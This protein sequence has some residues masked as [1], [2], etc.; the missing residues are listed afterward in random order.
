MLVFLNLSRVTAVGDYHK[1]TLKEMSVKPLF[2]YLIA[3]HRTGL[4]YTRLENHYY[5]ETNVINLNDKKK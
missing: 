4:E 1:H 2:K 3:K 5:L